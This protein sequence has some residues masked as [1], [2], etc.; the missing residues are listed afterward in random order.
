M[1]G[2]GWWVFV[3]DRER[4]EAEMLHRNLAKSQGLCELTSTLPRRASPTPTQIQS[5]AV[6]LFVASNRSHDPLWCLPSPSLHRRSEFLPP[7][8]RTNPTIYT[9]ESLDA[10]SIRPVV[11]QTDH[12]DPELCACL[13]RARCPLKPTV[14][15]WPNSTVN[16][17]EESTAVGTLPLQTSSGRRLL[18]ARRP[19]E[20]T[21]SIQVLLALRL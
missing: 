15:T 21:T 18:D 13:K 11:C 8:C 6:L 3:N 9:P 17:E 12:S 16:R 20:A 1:V 4:A 10:T 14:A 5:L 7:S 19:W 2:G